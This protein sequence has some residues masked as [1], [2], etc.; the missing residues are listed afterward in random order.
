MVNVGKSWDF[1]FFVFVFGSFWLV[2]EPPI[3]EKICLSKWE[4]CPNRGEN[5]N[6]CDTTTLEMYWKG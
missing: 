3:Y 5:P 6:M 2:V 4:S 1:V